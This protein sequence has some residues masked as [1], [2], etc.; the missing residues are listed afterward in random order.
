M[1]DY[2]AAIDKL[3]EEPFVDNDRLGAVGASYGGYS[4]YYLAGIHDGRFKTFISHCGVFNLQSWYGSTE[5]IFFANWDLGGAYWLQPEPASY[6]KF[7][8]H[9][10]VA[11]WDTPILV[12]H[13]QKDF[14]VPVSQ[15]ME[16]FSAAQLQDIPSKFLYFPNEG[17]WV[18]QPQNGILWHRVF[19]D[20]LDD[21]LK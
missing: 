13:G 1:R 20:W 14:R 4:V 7:S 8:P 5:E 11:N 3:A 9:E 19:F 16:A 17:H 15:G 21:Y 6:E 2:L 10:L 12:I 18:L